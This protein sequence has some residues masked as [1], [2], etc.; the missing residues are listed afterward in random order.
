ML[1]GPN[2]FWS[3]GL[4]HSGDLADSALL[5]DSHITSLGAAKAVEGS[6]VPPITPKAMIIVSREALILCIFPP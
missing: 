2:S 3:P 6:T 1:L 4:E 5:Q